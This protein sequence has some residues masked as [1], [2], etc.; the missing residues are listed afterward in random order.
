MNI[1]PDTA[2]NLLELWAHMNHLERRKKETFE[3]LVVSVM[4]KLAT[5]VRE[6]MTAYDWEQ[7]RAATEYAVGIKPGFH[8]PGR[9]YG[10]MV[11][12]HMRKS[13]VLPVRIGEM[14]QLVRNMDGKVIAENP[15]MNDY[16]DLSEVRRVYEAGRR[17]D[18]DS[19]D[20]MDTLAVTGSE[21]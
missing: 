7:L 2:L 10:R 18:S 8:P 9:I 12:T 6:S 3:K 1:K 16:F 19:G 11:P 20:G 15:D 4:H 13:D 21:C 17:S 14:R 5:E